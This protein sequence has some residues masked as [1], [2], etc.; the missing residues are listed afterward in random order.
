MIEQ[1]DGFAWD[2]TIFGSRIVG[3]SVIFVS[4]SVKSAENLDGSHRSFAR[5][6]YS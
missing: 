2:K 6:G 4:C 3:Q 1:S 5:T